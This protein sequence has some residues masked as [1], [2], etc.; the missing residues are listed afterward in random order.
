M[1][2]G[3]SVQVIVNHL[4]RKGT[5]AETRTEAGWPRF[6]TPDDCLEFLIAWQGRHDVL[7]G[8]VRQINCELARLYQ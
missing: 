6:D 2:D 7:S 8:L 5:S 1:L 4:C 3:P